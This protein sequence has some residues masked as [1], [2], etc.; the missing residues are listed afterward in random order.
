[1]MSDR[2]T[3]C[4]LLHGLRV[5]G[6]EVLAARLARRLAGSYRFVFACLEEVGTLGQELQAEGFPVE[7]LGRQPGI[8]WRC[9]RRLRR[10]LRRE[11]VELVHAHQYT[12]FFYSAM[13]RFPGRRPPILFTEHGRPYP[14]RPR[15]KRI[16]ANRVLLGRRD[17]VV[18]VGQ[19]VRQALIENEGIAGPR[20]EVIHNGIDL[21]AFSAGGDRLALRSEFGLGV[22]DLVLLQVARLDPY[23][24]HSAALRMIEIV[25]KSRPEARLVLVGEG[26][27]EESIR[28]MIRQGGLESNVRLLGLRTD[29]A[30]LL[31]M[32]DLFL[33]T[34]V[35]EGI[36]VTL[37]EAMAASLTIVGTRVGGMA[38]VVEEGTTGLLSPSGDAPSLAESV[39]RLS[40]DPGLR[41]RMGRLGA[42]R[43]HRLFSEPQMHAGYQRCYET[44]LGFPRTEPVLEHPSPALREDQLTPHG[45]PTVFPVRLSE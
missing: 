5:G 13:A 29:V 35:T 30:R 36:P 2:P 23:K 4:Q 11:R 7:V 32:A 41:L 21:A 26:P 19:A 15:P 17:R 16:A 27:E 45:C 34:S 20:I 14:D 8:D 10:L 6:A 42:E 9:M 39:L 33:L 37:I 3:I 28:S 44:M 43:A 24:D 25:A 40:A 22:D 1:M 31:P 12:P 18:A 38:E